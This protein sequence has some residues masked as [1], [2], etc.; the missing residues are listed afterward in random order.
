MT[1]RGD[2]VRH[3][4]ILLPQTMADFKTEIDIYDSVYRLLQFKSFCLIK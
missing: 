4:Y 3:Q 1:F 2:G